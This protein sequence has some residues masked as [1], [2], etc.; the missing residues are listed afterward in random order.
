MKRSIWFAYGV[1][2]HGMFLALFFYMVGFL[3][4]FMVPK[5]IDSGAEGGFGLALAVN[6]GLLAVFGASHSIMARPTFK[7]WWT[8]L[9]P[10]PIER[11]TYVLV[12]NLFMVLLLWQ[13]SPMPSVIW[14]VQ[15]PAAQV[16]LWALF[17]LGWLLIFI[18]SLLINHF[19]LFGTRQVWLYLRGQE[20]TPP[21]FGT[22]ALYKMVRHPIYVGWLLAF[23]VTPTMTVG[24]L[25]FSVGTTV[26]ILIAIQLEERNLTELHPEYDAYRR[27]VPML[28]PFMKPRLAVASPA[29]EQSV[30]GP[31]S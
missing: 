1:L 29:S 10:V 21:I 14:D 7:R 8:K 3:A 28:I 26:Y 11:A 16:V 13:W 20:Y 4:N 23:W 27:R 9:V 15:A 24:H 12:S 2:C 30:E 18:A 25:V 19:D 31:G 5:G 17:G 6:L 22:P